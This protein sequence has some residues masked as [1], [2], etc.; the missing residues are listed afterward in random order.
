MTS[1]SD[2][3]SSENELNE[4]QIEYFTT[5]FFNFSQTGKITN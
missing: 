2:S 1:Q 3:D 4:E 5:L